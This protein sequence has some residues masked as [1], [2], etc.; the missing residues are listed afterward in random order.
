MKKQV[1]KKATFTWTL[2]IEFNGLCAAEVL[3][4][5]PGQKEMIIHLVNDPMHV[6]VLCVRQRDLVD[7][8]HCAPVYKLLARDNS[9]DGASTL[10]VWPITRGA[11]MSIMDVN[12]TSL[13]VNTDKRQFNPP[14]KPG[15]T[16]TPKNPESL[17]WLPILGEILASSKCDRRED[18]AQFRLTE[19]S[20][21][22]SRLDPNRVWM[23][24]VDGKVVQERQLAVTILYRIKR[25]NRFPVVLDLHPGMVAVGPP[26]DA[27]S[28][29]TAELTISNLPVA[30]HEAPVHVANLLASRHG[31]HIPH[32]NEYNRLVNTAK[33]VTISEITTN[34]V[35]VEDPIH[36]FDA[37]VVA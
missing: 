13:T 16:P 24:D 4:G 25:S 5:Q 23:I 31:D 9:G 2:L 22:P 33:V 28:G 35:T 11:L 3:K 15:G 6:P 26:E 37:G 29:Y 14:P 1:K 18:F 30:P 12:G 27:V 10:G 21:I 36:C 20:V 32:F 34:T 17:L 7:S 19:G 8:H